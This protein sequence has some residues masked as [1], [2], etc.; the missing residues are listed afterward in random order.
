MFGG[1]DILSIPKQSFLSL[2][3]SSLTLQLFLSLIFSHQKT[4]ILLRV[5]FCLNL[6]DVTENGTGFDT[7]KTNTALKRG[8]TLLFLRTCKQIRKNPCDTP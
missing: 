5:F 7:L 6:Q 8:C 3:N 1:A 2:K 4:R